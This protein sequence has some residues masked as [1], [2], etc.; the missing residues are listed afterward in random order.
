LGG[1]DLL[2]LLDMETQLWQFAAGIANTLRRVQDC[3][4]RRC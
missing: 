2:R 4:M 3:R 1:N